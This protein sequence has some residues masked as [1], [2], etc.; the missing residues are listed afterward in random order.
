MNKGKLEKDAIFLIVSDL[1]Y[2]II[3]SIGIIIRAIF[4]LFIVLLGNKLSNMFIIVAIFCGIPETLYWSTHE[5][6]FL[7]ITNNGN[8]KSYMATKKI[9]STIFFFDWTT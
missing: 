7:S 9:V 1:I 8:M 6:I 5:M 4:I 2:T 3:L